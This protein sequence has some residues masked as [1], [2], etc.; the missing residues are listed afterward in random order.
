MPLLGWHRRR[1]WPSALM[2]HCWRPHLLQHEAVEMAIYNGIEGAYPSGP[3]G[4]GCPCTQ[5]VACTAH[6]N[7]SWDPLLAS[8]ETLAEA[9]TRAQECTADPKKDGC[10]ALV[11]GGH[12]ATGPGVI[13]VPLSRACCRLPTHAL[14]WLAAGWPSYSMSASPHSKP[15]IRSTH[16]SCSQG[17]PQ[18]T[19][20]ALAAECQVS[21]YIH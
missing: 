21:R 13:S 19:H 20:T 10:G 1:T 4:F 12:W 9:T 6:R 17:T 3:P 5:S 11:S 15:A 18:G 7:S 16:L 14:A 8:R 2:A